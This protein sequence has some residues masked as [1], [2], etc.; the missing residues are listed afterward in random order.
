MS[1]GRG[2]EKAPK[3]D[4]EAAMHENAMARSRERT[5]WHEAASGETLHCP[6]E[7]RSHRKMHAITRRLEGFGSEKVMERR[8]GECDAAS[9]W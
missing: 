1:G 6:H 2:Q 3:R 7:S 4:G 5:R 9:L 8:S